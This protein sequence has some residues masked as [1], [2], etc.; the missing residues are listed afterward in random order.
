MPT[1]HNLIRSLMLGCALLLTLPAQAAVNDAPAVKKKVVKKGASKKV[2]PA[3]LQVDED[4]PDTKDA[5][6]TEFNCELGNKLA[7]FH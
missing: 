7:I 1:S 6:Q 3:P 2:A 5:V 4:V